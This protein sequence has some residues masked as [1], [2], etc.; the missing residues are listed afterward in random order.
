MNRFLIGV[1]L[2][3][4]VV[5]CTLAT[6]DSQPLGST[7]AGGTSNSQLFVSS[8]ACFGG[9]GVTSATASNTIAA[10]DLQTGA[11][12]RTVLDYN[13]F[14]PGDSPVGIADFDKE[15]MLVMVENT[16]GRR[17]DLV[18]KDGSGVT[19]YITNATALN[20]VLRG[21]RRAADGS[22]FVA[23]ATAIEKFSASKARVVIAANPY[24]NN[25]QGGCINSNTAVSGVTLLSNNKIL[26]THAGATP[27]NKLGLVSAAGYTVAGD[28]LS[29]QAAPNTTAI[30][31]AVL[32]HPNG[33]VFVSYGSGTITSNFI[34]SYDLNITTNVFSNATQAFADN[35]VVNGPSAMAVDPVTGIVYVASALNTFNTIEAFSVSGGTLT[36]IGVLPFAGPNIYT[37]CISGMQVLESP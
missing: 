37:R 1:V 5:G 12:R 28:C 35:G 19:S 15:Q 22:V 31:T 36:R 6:E 24:V 30:P 27:N 23:K 33:K 10:F 7:L 8:G 29:S 2:S 25:P 18:K 16:A 20:A 9:T 21:V 3:L 4:V 14:S 11:Y 34:F 32:V 26:Y 17:I 13:V